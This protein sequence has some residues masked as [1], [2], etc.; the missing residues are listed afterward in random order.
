MFRFLHAADLHLD[1]PLRSLDRYEGAPAE[2]LRRAGR[3][4]LENLG[5]LA[6]QER[7]RFVLLVGDLF[8]GD[9][10]DVNTGLFFVKQMAKLREAGIVVYLIYGNHDA[11]NRMT[12]S[13][14]YPENVHVFPSEQPTTLLVDGLPV[15]LHGQSYERQYVRDNLAARY[16][17][18][19]AGRFN[20][21]LL[22]TAL[23]GREGHETYAPCSVEELLARGYDYW[24][25][26]HAHQ[27]ESVSPNSRRLIE[28]PGNTQGRHIRETGAKG[29]LIVRVDSNHNMVKEF[30]PLDVCR[31][32]RV[33]VD[34]QAVDAREELLKRVEHALQAALDATEGRPLAARVVLHGPCPLHNQLLA[35]RETFRD[36][37]LA[38]GIDLASYRLWIEQVEVRT[39]APSA[40]A[41]R[42]ELAEDAFSEILRVVQQLREDSETLRSLLDATDL[43][44]LRNRLPPELRGGEDALD[45]SAPDLAAELL[46]RA[47]AMLRERSVSVENRS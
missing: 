29:C 14:P 46:E 11:A 17:A 7:V 19:E 2:L 13:L 40:D 38:R 1:S 37:I 8:D 33:E 5:K 32:A 39:A 21:G 12:R 20:I 4:A 36:D 10:P 6:A 23:N 25:L 42:L 30:H 22:H 27:R 15:A 16:P 18:P 35:W 44:H 43:N 26:G 31:W 34:C 24:A 28:F 9:W 45:F 41:D 47:C 3:A